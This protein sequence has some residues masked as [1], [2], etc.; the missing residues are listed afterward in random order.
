MAQKWGPFANCDCHLLMALTLFASP[1]VERTLG[2]PE[3]RAQGAGEEVTVEFHYASNDTK[4][5]AGFCTA[6]K[7]LG[8]KASTGTW[9]KAWKPHP[10]AEWRL[11]FQPLE[12][13][14]IKSLVKNDFN[15]EV[16]SF[17]LFSFCFSSLLLKPY[18]N[19]ILVL[20][21][22]EITFSLLSQ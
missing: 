15:S 19:C 12:K 22:I 10:A 16:F 5:K 4:R 8:A 18:Q 13:V 6:G 14:G 2:S 1:Q 7:T 9:W 11:V 17:F 21:S 3:I 20:Q